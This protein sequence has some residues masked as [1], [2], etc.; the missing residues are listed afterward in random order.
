MKIK[1]RLIGIIKSHVIIA[2]GLLVYAIGWTGFLLPNH[3]TGGG[4]SGSGRIVLCN[5]ISGWYQR[6]DF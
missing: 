3:I 6:F 5:W 2:F 4:I 1:K